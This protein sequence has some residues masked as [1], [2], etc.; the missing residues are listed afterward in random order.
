MDTALKKM[1]P[2]F[3][4]SGQHKI[5]IE[6]FL[7]REGAILLDVRSREE[8]NALRFDLDLFRISC[9]NIPID[10]LP[11]HYPELPG[12][13]FI[14]VFCSSGTRSAWAYIYLFSKGYNVRWIEGGNEELARMLK[15]GRLHKKPS[16]NI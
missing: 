6:K 3:C 8:V 2:E 9:L 12:D 4:G 5:S 15:P 10:E 16:E 14:G 7:E 13:R 11:D 1:T